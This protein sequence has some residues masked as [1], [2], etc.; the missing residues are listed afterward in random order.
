MTNISNSIFIDSNKSI[1]EKIKNF[2]AIMKLIKESNNENSK[3]KY[4]KIAYDILSTLRHHIRKN[5]F[6]NFIRWLNL[7]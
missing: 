7:S 1:N 5:E 6:N 3:L 2:K 4:K